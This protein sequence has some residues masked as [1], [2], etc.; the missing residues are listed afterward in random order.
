MSIFLDSQ[1]Q[2]MMQLEEEKNIHLFSV[3]EGKTREQAIEES[4]KSGLINAYHRFFIQ[5]AKESVDSIFNR[6][7][8]NLV[9]KC[10]YK[11]FVISESKSSSNNIE[12]N[13]HLIAS[14]NKLKSFLNYKGFNADFISTDFLLKIEQSKI[15]E[16]SEIQTAWSCLFTINPLL[17][18]SFVYTITAEQ[19]RSFNQTNS[20]WSIPVK[21]NVSTNEHIEFVFRYLKAILR[22]I[23]LTK[24]EEKEYLTLNLPVYSFV[25]DNEKYILRKKETLEALSQFF[26]DFH[27]AMRNFYIYDGVKIVTGHDLLEKSCSSCGEWRAT[28]YTCFY[29]Y[30]A[31]YNDV[32]GIDKEDPGCSYNNHD[33]PYSGFEKTTIDTRRLIQTVVANNFESKKKGTFLRTYSTVL[34]YSLSELSKTKPFL[35]ES[36][37][38]NSPI[39]S[40]FKGGR[41]FFIDRVQTAYIS[42]ILPNANTYLQGI[43]LPSSNSKDTINYLLNKIKTDTSIGSGKS[44]TNKLLQEV[45]YETTPFFNCR[46]YKFHGLNDWFLPSRNEMLE[47]LKFS[48]LFMNKN[49]DLG[50]CPFEKGIISKHCGVRDFATSTIYDDRYRE[51][52]FYSIEADY[53]K[54]SIARSRIESRSF[55]LL[56]SDGYIRVIPIRTHIYKNEMKSLIDF[57]FLN[58]LDSNYTYFDFNGSEPEFNAFDFDV[59]MRRYIERNISE[60]YDDGKA[61][62]CEISFVVSEDGTVSQV[63]AVNMKETAL[64]RVAAEAILKGPKWKPALS[65]N[66]KPVSYKMTK[67]ITYILPNNQ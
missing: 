23:S 36:N 1:G 27:W 64:A 13:I 14:L 3:G 9:Q 47:F 11:Q 31:N 35:V 46:S 57:T 17:H 38:K 65:A 33:G 20:V 7:I 62:T 60:I 61:G 63:E 29:V 19:P 24:E 30:N 21:I 37:F 49:P 40:W 58:D 55:N 5:S 34:I 66:G 2:L 59:Y 50:T 51:P 26:S 8:K 16:E 39:G 15:N 32:N 43:V 67:K 42:P 45:Y 18:Q 44:N 6:E 48:H 4:I 28:N 12:V 53:S 22:Q 25:I 52:L 54:Y 10:V 56:N 41:I